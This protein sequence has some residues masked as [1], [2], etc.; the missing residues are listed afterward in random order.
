MSNFF[1]QKV[2]HGGTKWNPDYRQYVETKAKQATDHAGTI[3]QMMT[4]LSG[5]KYGIAWAGIAHAK[6]MP[7]VKAI[8][9]REGDTG[10]YIP[11][12]PA[13]VSDRSYPL[14]RSIYIQ[15]N[16]PPGTALDPKIKEFLRF[17]LSRLGQIDVQRQG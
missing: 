13:T 8:A 6:D 10:T 14:T 12:T 1:E 2:F 9:L 15:L 17:V 16:R 11:C 3:A 7:N 4:D 5:D